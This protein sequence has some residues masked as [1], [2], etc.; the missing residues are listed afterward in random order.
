MP[1]KNS[2]PEER[3]EYLRQWRAR[4]PDYM[5]RWRERNPTYFRDYDKT[6]Q[7]RAYDLAYCAENR[8]RRR[9]INRESYARHPETWVASAHR[10]RSRVLAAP[11]AAS[12]EQLRARIAFYGHR[13]AYCRGVFEHVDHV[14]P[15]SR[16]G[17]NWPANLRPACAPCNLS[18][19]NLTLRE[20]KGR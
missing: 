13:C 14:I 8:E 20:W 19:R 11:G 6:P 9:E 10:R 3:R 2:T 1:G 5:R 18:K 15:L 7:R 17:S 16:G 4:N 12:A